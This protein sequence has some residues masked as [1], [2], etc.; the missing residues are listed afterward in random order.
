[1]LRVRANSRAHS[2]GLSVSERNSEM[3]VADAMVAA[4]AVELPGDAADEGR[5]HEPDISTSAMAISAIPTSS[6]ETRAACS[7]KSPSFSLR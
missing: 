6:M 4:T 5:R 3:A 7:R 1:M 2:A